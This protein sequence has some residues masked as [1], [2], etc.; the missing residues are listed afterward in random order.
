MIDRLP[1]PPSALPS[2]DASPGRATVGSIGHLMVVPRAAGPLRDVDAAAGRPVDELDAAIDELFG[3]PDDERAGP[4]DVALVVGGIGLAGWAFV[5]GGH[6]PLLA[7]GI[8]SALLGSALPA[9]S[10]TQA[11]RERRRSEDRDRS[12]GDGLPLDASEPTVHALVGAY[13]GCLR[14]A[15]KPG[16][17]GAA[18]ATD[19]AH[20]AMVEVASLLAGGRP[21]A[22]AELEYVRKR[23]GAIQRLT[24]RLQEVQRARVE[25]RMDLSIHRTPTGPRWATAVTEAREELEA[26]G[27][28]GSLDRMAEIATALE[29]EASHVAR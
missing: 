13:D 17:P 14:A 4:L 5:T 11:A 28:L 20:Q 1:Q 2:V 16:L 6:E 15:S 22:D 7:V 19:A 27:G 24:V 9:R 8:A 18:A 12:I 29:S 3:E 26:T 23:T 21:V 25:A 10:M